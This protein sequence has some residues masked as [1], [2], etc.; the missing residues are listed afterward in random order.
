MNQDVK[1]L[2]GVL[3]N[4]EH[5]GK[6]SKSSRCTVEAEETDEW[7]RVTLS[8]Q[9]NKIVGPKLAA[10]ITACS[11]DRIRRLLDYIRKLEQDARRYAWLRD[12]ADSKGLCAVH[13]QYWSEEYSSQAE[14]DVLFGAILDEAIDAHLPKEAT[15]GK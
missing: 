4:V 1:A 5:C 14:I 13:V 10:Y 3:A 12:H 8:V 2:D 11:P 7:P 9:A 15:N 6:F